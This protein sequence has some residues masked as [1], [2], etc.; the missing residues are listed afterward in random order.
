MPRQ[1]SDSVPQPAA[2]DLAALQTEL[3]AQRTLLEQIREDNKQIKRRLFYMALGSYLRLALI[4][5]PLLVGLAFVIPFFQENWEQMQR[6]LEMS[7]AVTDQSGFSLW[8]E[9]ER[10]GIDVNDILPR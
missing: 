7:Q 8:Q 5:I 6:L 10:Q 3:S 9:L 2:V 4:V 1:T